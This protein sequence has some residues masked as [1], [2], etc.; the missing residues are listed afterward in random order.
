MAK[1]TEVNIK[2]SVCGNTIVNKDI[3]KK[4]MG[5]L[6][7]KC[8]K[9]KRCWCVDYTNEKVTWVKGKKENTPI[10]EFSLDLSTGNSYPILN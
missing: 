2:C 4:V 1:K 8:S 9:C 5:E 6:N 7:H 10:K 3:D